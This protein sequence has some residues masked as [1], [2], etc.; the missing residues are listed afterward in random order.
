MEKAWRVISL[1]DSQLITPL[2]ELI[3]IMEK[4]FKFLTPS[5]RAH[6]KSTEAQSLQGTV[7]KSIKYH[8]RTSKSEV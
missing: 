4:E 6:M 1:V 7:W 2:G 5:I 8:A 3:A